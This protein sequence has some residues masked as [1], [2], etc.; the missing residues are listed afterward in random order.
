M[1]FYSASQSVLIQLQVKA[2]L[3]SE[4]DREHT[5]ESTVSVFS[6]G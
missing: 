2:A 3:S 5:L 6:K 1:N 4:A